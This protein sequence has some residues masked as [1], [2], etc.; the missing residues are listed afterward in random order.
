MQ[1][2]GRYGQVER[3]CAGDPEQHGL[4][5][6]TH[7]TVKRCQLTNFNL[8]RWRRVA[9]F[10]PHHPDRRSLAETP[11]RGHHAKG[12]ICLLDESK[13]RAQ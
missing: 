3:R 12:P 5:R 7:K 9:S 6:S 8:P 2:S 10:G 13:L 1:I 11:E 4:R